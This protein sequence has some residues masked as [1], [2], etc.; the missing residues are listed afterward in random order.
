[1]FIDIVFAK[2]NEEE[3]LERAKVLGSKLLFVYKDNPKKIA[4]AHSGLLKPGKADLILGGYERKYF[5][6]PKYKVL[7]GFELAEKKDGLHKRNSGLNH[8]LCR[9]AAEK[10]KVLAFDFNNLLYAK[11]KQVVLGRMKQNAVLIRKYGCEHLVAS[12][13]KKP[14]DM[15]AGK[16]YEALLQE[17][18][19]DGKQ[20]KQATNSLSG[21][22]KQ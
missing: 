13:A 7:Y 22:I 14:E 17:L 21:L 18:G 8:V 10:G 11:D 6:N 1:M 4:G 19:F 12:F 2:G 3:F 20:A 9:L 5:E 16:D 15:R